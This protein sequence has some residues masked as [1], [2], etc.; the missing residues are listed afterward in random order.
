M[1]RCYKILDKIA[2]G[3]C[4]WIWPK[5]VVG[6]SKWRTQAKCEITRPGVN[7]AK[8]WLGHPFLFLVWS[9]KGFH[10]EC[11][12]LGAV[13]NHFPVYWAIFGM[14]TTNKHPNNQVILVQACP[15]PVRRQSFAIFLCQT[16]WSLPPGCVNGLQID[17][18]P[19]WP[20]MSNSQWRL[21]P[22]LKWMK[23]V[24]VV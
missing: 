10:F 18:V 22:T 7:Y 6:L 21:E 8:D 1:K 23:N 20:P 17:G 16:F 5:N 9:G 15:W 24:F 12:H 4:W 19:P 2:F 11:D 3:F 13:N 14:V